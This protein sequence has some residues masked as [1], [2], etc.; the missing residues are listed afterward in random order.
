MK[1][2]VIA[3][4][5]ILLSF[6]FIGGAG[7]QAPAPKSADSTPKAAGEPE[8]KPEKSKAKASQSGRTGKKPDASIDERKGKN[9]E[10]PPRGIEGP[11]A[12]RSKK[13]DASAKPP[14][15]KGAADSD[16]GKEQKKP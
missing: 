16:V 12:R 6:W 7:A 15:S 9:V 8:V 13:S 4:A 3:L 1:N 14:N 11:D 5:P 10:G 2:I